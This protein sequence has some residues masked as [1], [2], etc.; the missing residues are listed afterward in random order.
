MG[1]KSAA[2]RPHKAATPHT[3]R[4]VAALSGAAYNTTCSKP[5]KIGHQEGAIRLCNASGVLQGDAC[6]VV[7]IGIGG[8]WQMEQ[9]LVDAGCTVHAFDPTEMFRNSH[10]KYAHGKSR[11]HFHYAGL[12]P[13]NVTDGGTTSHLLCKQEEEQRRRRLSITSR[14]Q[15]YGSIDVAR[16]LPLD[17]IL[18]I[19]LGQRDFA[20]KRLTLLKI[21]CEGALTVALIKTITS[22]DMGDMHCEDDQSLTIVLDS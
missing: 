9:A 8:F 4:L 15:K 19:A 11:L 20:N 18:R 21:D 6:T 17:D 14:F 13:R 2:A 1:T 12:A 16:L 10:T 3:K 5:V 22:K 7:S